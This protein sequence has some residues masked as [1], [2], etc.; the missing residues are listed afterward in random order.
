M[1][2][3]VVSAEAGGS[4]QADFNLCSQT[5]AP[6]NGPHDVVAQPDYVPGSFLPGPASGA[7]GT[8]MRTPVTIDLLGTE[9]PAHGAYAIGAY[10][11]PPPIAFFTAEGR[12]P[13]APA[14]SRP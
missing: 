6:Y 14:S 13:V 8:G 3:L 10:E 2:R 9:R 7:I 1:T 4:Y 11:Y 5:L 12:A